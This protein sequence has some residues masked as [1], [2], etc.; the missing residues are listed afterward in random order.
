MFRAFR[1]GF[2]GASVESAADIAC[3]GFQD[4]RAD[5]MGGPGLRSAE[6]GAAFGVLFLKGSSKRLA[7]ERDRRDNDPEHHAAPPHGRERSARREIADKDA[8]AYL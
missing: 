5:L 7:R 8:G 4:V 2:P 3:I 6:F 1:W